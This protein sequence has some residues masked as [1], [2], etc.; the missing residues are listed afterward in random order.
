MLK[1]TTKRF[2]TKHLIVSDFFPVRKEFQIN[3]SKHSVETFLKHNL[4]I[5]MW[6][7]SKIHLTAYKH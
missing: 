2:N 3:L 5:N 1:N 6:L 7:L 4:C